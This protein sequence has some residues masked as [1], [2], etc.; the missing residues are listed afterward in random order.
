MNRYG[1][2]LNGVFIMIIIKLNVILKLRVLYLV[3][4]FIWQLHDMRS[5]AV[6]DPGKK[7][8]NTLSM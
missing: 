7:N 3:Y 4:L 1:L 8:I 2:L 6:D 5:I